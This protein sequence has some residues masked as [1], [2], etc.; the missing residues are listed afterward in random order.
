MVSFMLRLLYCQGIALVPFE[1]GLDWDKSWCE[2]F[3]EEE[4]LLLLLEIEL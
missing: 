3:K 2:D 4:N 1:F